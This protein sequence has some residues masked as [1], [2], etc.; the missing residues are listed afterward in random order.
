MEWF[1]LVAVFIVVAL[2]FVLTRTGDKAKAPPPAANP[3]NP[4]RDGGNVDD[5]NPANKN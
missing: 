4:P 5:G 1:I 2:T 3:A